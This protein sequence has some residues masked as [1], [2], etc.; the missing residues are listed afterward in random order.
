MR[1]VARLARTEFTFLPRRSIASRTT[2]RECLF[3]AEFFFHVGD[4]MP[5]NQLQEW[6]VLTSYAITYHLIDDVPL[7]SAQRL[8]ILSGVRRFMRD[9]EVFRE[10]F[11]DCRLYIGKERIL[12]HRAAH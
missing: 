2:D 3:L 8:G 12:A 10:C 5:Q 4:I 1:L 11:I 9:A 6:S 7:R